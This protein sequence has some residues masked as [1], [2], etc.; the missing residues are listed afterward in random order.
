MHAMAA[1]W[2]V[3]SMLGGNEEMW[4][5][6]GKWIPGFQKMSVCNLSVRWFDPG[7]WQESDS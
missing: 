2:G 6:W 4:G 7:Q 1:E 5:G 3:D